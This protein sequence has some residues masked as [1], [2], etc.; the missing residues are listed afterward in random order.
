M[1]KP[2]GR[3]DH[4][5]HFEVQELKMQ[6]CLSSLVYKN[7]CNE[8][9]NMAVNKT[10]INIGQLAFFCD[11]EIQLAES[12]LEGKYLMVKLSRIYQLLPGPLIE[13]RNANSEEVFK[14]LNESENDS[15]PYSTKIKCVYCLSWNSKIGVVI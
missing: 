10:R 7:D 14:R 3:L 9:K 6:S 12:I 5:F 8:G 15:I 11:V 13:N 2:A 1:K 4:R